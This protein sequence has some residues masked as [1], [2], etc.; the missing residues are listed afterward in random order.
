MIDDEIAMEWARIPHFYYNFY[1]YQYATG[2][3]AAI[4]LSRKILS[5]GAQAAQAYKGFL[6]GGCSKTPIEL[7]C[8]AGVD[9]NTTAPITEALSLFGE[10]I[11]ELE[12]LMK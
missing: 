6:K 7:L 5:G 3:S 10:L 8:D 11:D 12:E 2:Y 9:M 1:V 4:A